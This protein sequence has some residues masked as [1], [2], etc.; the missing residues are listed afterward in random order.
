MKNKIIITI[1]LVL[2]FGT[3]Q[4][5]S[6]LATPFGGRIVS[7]HECFCSGGWMIYVLDAGTKTT[8]PIL[9]QFGQSSLKANWNI[10]T[11]GVN[12]LGTYTP[13]GSCTMA[14]TYCEVTITA[15]GT[16][17]TLPGIGTSLSP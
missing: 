17:S 13:S 15:T 1:L 5:S 3:P 6:A 2:S 14:T 16:V 9:F 11:Y 7:M 8:I 12:V 4:I 10:F